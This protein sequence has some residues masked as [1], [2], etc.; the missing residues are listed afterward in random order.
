[1][2]TMM[3]GLVRSYFISPHSVLRV[4]HENITKTSLKA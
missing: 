2:A 4:K 1:M 3:W